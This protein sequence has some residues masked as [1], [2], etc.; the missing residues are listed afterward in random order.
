MARSISGE[1]NRAVETIRLIFKHYDEGHPGTGIFNRSALHVEADDQR[2]ALWEAYADGAT[3][4]GLARRFE[5]P[6]AWVYRAITE[7]RAR[8]LRRRKIEFVDSPDFEAPEAEAWILST[9]EGV[10]IR[11]ELP[12][13]SRRVPAGLPPYLAQLFRIPLLTAEGELVLFRKMN[14]LKFKASRLCEQLD[15]ETAR[16]A[17]LDHIEDLLGQAAQ[18]KKEIVQ[19]NL[20]LVV[21][22]GKRHIR[23]GH[24]LFEI[25]SDG[26]ISLMRAVDKFDY[27]RG[28]KF[29]T[30]ASWA[31]MKNYARSVPEQR[32][33]QD[34]YQ[35]GWDEM[36]DNLASF[37]PD[38]TE[39]DY[40]VA[41]RRTLDDM[42]ATLD[43]RECS[44]L[45]DA[46]AW[47]PTGSRKRSNRSAA[48]S[49]C[50]KN[51]F[52]RSSRGR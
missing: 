39:S 28:F 46:T 1:T 9:A 17:E 29:S 41:V 44:I 47:T 24:D 12:A 16:A 3:V 52:D 7:M 22:I 25:I 10:A 35:T 51:G 2:L 38:Q 36:L 5:K 42:L 13:S 40:L 20:R 43:E 31:V 49:G 50:R 48:V 27:T 32:H 30:Y 18:V 45:R 15:P 14:Y 19:A 34:R 21:A 23:P 4:E 26:N 6:I 8:D 37:Q 33:H 11:Q